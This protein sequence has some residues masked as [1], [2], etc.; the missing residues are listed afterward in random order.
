M[1]EWNLPSK[2]IETE[3]NNASSLVKLKLV[4]ELKR[5]IQNESDLIHA[6]DLL[7]DLK[8]ETDIEIRNIRIDNFISQ[9]K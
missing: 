6:L 4:H 5:R 1:I 2:K 3:V 7:E 9:F 8:R